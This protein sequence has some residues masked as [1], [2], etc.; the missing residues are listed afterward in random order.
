MLT[1]FEL[2]HP[3]PPKNDRTIVATARGKG[4][5]GGEVVTYNPPG[6]GGARRRG[7]G[8]GRAASSASAVVAFLGPQ[9]ARAR[10]SPSMSVD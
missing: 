3:P 4:P 5:T 9:T 8:R 10:V 7:R 2:D 1:F 6:G